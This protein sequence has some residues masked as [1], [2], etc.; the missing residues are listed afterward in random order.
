M[1][2]VYLLFRL[3]K[4]N[5]PQSSR[6]HVEQRTMLKPPEPANIAPHT[7]SR[8]Q[9]G[10]GNCEQT[11]VITSQPKA[12]SSQAKAPSTR[13]RTKEPQRQRKARVQTEQEP[14]PELAAA[15][16]SCDQITEIAGEGSREV[17]AKSR[18]T[19]FDNKGRRRR[20]TADEKKKRGY[21]EMC[22]VTFDDFAKVSWDIVKLKCYLNIYL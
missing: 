14:V 12:I 2:D 15:A 9:G 1:H 3:P 10:A 20:P 4:R 13:E 19:R 17:K 5:A 22:A 21:C 8:T 11:K 6:Q 7:V 18:D 16:K